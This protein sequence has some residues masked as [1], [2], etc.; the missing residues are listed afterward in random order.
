M[1]PDPGL[2]LR[3]P[4]GSEARG[5]YCTP[6][7][8]GLRVAGTVELAG[9]DAPP[10]YARAEVLLKHAIRY[11]PGLQTAEAERWMGPRPSF[12]D[13]K[14]VISGLKGEPGVLLAFGHGHIGLTLAAV[15]GRAIADMAAGRATVADMTP[16]RADRF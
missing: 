11:Y 15:T 12:P 4:V 10:N 5:F 1:L 8:D 13:S 3:I 6:M 7:A 9:L 14:P 16:F 2:D